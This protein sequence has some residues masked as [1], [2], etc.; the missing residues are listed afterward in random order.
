M[1]WNENE[2]ESLSF[3]CSFAWAAKPTE[4]SQPDGPLFD[5]PDEPGA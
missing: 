3:L 2:K 1:S 5:E 4:K